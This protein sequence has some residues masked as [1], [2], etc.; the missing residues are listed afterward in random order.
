MVMFGGEVMKSKKKF[1]AVASALETAVAYDDN[2]KYELMVDAASQLRTILAGD[3]VALTRADKVRV[4]KSLTK[5]KVRAFM[6]GSPESYRTF[7][8]LDSISTDI[9]RLL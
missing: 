5:A 7:R 8:T 6:K 1:M 2:S 9:V 4:L 3:E